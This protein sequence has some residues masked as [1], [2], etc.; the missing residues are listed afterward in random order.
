[1]EA[2][3]MA[4]R[5]GRPARTDDVLLALVT[6][7]EVA[8]AYPHLTGSVADRYDGTR[9]LLAGVDRDELAA[10]VAAESGDDEVPLKSLLKAGPGGPQDTATLLRALTAHPG[11]RAAR[12]L[13]SL[14]PARTPACA[15]S[16]A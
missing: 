8:T 6:T 7:F 12:V 4:R 3:E 9:A 15:G 10:A 2:D 13:R 16:R 14:A 5:S 1:L 11:T